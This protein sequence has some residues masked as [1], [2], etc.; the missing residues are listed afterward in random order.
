VASLLL[1][2]AS[3]VLGVVCLVNFGKGLAEYLHA[4]DALAS[5]DFRHEMF[6][7]DE[8]KFPHDDEK[9]SKQDFVLTF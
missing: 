7:H 4:E 3:M 6:T 8:E 5:M 1:L 2:I 9:D